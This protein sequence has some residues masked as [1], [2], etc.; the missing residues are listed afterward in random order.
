MRAQLKL[1]C[2]V[3]V[4]HLLSMLLEL[5]TMYSSCRLRL[6]YM[7]QIDA[8]RYL[9]GVAE[10]ALHLEIALFLLC[11]GSIEPE[12]SLRHIGQV[13]QAWCPGNRST[14]YKSITVSA[15][16]GSTR[17]ARHGV[18]TPDQSS[19]MKDCNTRQSTIHTPCRMILQRTA[20]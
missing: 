15:S 14:T 7:C 8:T 11:A 10:G 18:S 1:T 16:T 5:L 9:T 17:S 12:V 4:W 3:C 2:P 20:A 19:H 13:G 6:C